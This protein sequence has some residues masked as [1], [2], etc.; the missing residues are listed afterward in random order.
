MREESGKLTVVICLTLSGAPTMVLLRHARIANIA[1]VLD[2]RTSVPDG[3]SL[4]KCKISSK[5]MSPSPRGAPTLMSGTISLTAE[6]SL[7]LNIKLCLL[8]NRLRNE[9][10][11]PPRW[12]V[13]IYR[14][15]EPVLLQHAHVF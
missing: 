14:D 4:S 5:S 1:R 12:L 2:E 6:E 9:F 13:P 10:Q 7:T 11:S 15:F 3:Q 8:A